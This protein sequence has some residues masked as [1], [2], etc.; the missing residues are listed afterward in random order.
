MY[1]QPCGISPQ[2]LGERQNKQR[3][4]IIKI[5]ITRFLYFFKSLQYLHTTYT[6]AVADRNPTPLNSNNKYPF[7]EICV[8]SPGMTTFWIS[9]ADLLFPV[10]ILFS[11]PF[12]STFS[13]PS[14]FSH[15]LRS[16]FLPSFLFSVAMFWAIPY[17]QISK[18]MVKCH[19]AVIQMNHLL[20]SVTMP[21]TYD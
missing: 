21:Q 19:Y 15:L 6:T 4:L 14:P 10:L 11:Y 12:L 7:H 17:G 8:I 16:F 3:F 5:S 13:V 9:V 1:I 18:P 20:L 2:T